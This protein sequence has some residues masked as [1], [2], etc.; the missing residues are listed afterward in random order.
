MR[1]RRFLAAAAGLLISGALIGAP[2]AA[3][4]AATG[5]D[6]AK[7]KSSWDL[8]S[9]VNF[10]GSTLPDGCVKYTG[11]YTAGD[12]AWSEK[13]ATMTG[14]ELKLKVEKKK[15]SKQ[16][17]TTGGMGCWNWP[18]TYGKFEIKAKVPAGAGINSYITLSPANDK[19]VNGLTSI[20]LLAPDK[21]TAYISNGY[22]K[23]SEQA[24]S[25]Q[26]FA[27][28]WH[29]YTI[30]WAP[31]HLLVQLDGKEIFWS[32][33]A[34]KGSRWISMATTTGDSLTGTPTAATKLPKYFEI[35]SMK[36]YKYTGVKPTPGTTLSVSAAGATPSAS[37]SPG[38]SASASASSTAV[39]AAPSKKTASSSNKLTG[40]IWPWLI[41][42][43]VMVV[44]A[45][46]ILSYPSHRR[47][48]QQKKRE[49]AQAQRRQPDTYSRPY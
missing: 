12:S 31:N 7:K 44:T 46:V 45:L 34:Y 29:T 48:K 42:G 13:N 1:P 2:I 49:Q 27:K 8:K 41:G 37:A 43:S 33:Q 9:E 22:G 21:D 6:T 11:A 4:S 19:S 16:P 18:Q 14:G 38:A 47:H 30:E 26:D 5:T 28:A 20:E 32:D 35:T 3:A 25:V 36:M 24:F 39:A 40:G 15:T 17:Y 23:A 10:N